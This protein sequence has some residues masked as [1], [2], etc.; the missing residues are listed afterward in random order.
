MVISIY[1][2]KKVKGECS[3]KNTSRYCLS[4]VCIVCKALICKVLCVVEKVLLKVMKLHMVNIKE[5]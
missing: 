2:A 4:L 1:H 3:V 5:N